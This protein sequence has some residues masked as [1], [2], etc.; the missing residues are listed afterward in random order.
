[1]AD[2]SIA[3]HIGEKSMRTLSCLSTCLCAAQSV[4]IFFSATISYD[5]YVGRRYNSSVLAGGSSSGGPFRSS[6]NYLETLSKIHTHRKKNI[7]LEYDGNSKQKPKHEIMFRRRQ[8]KTQ[9]TKL[10]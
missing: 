4:Q 5:I 3:V 9:D 2:S 10:S 1:M 6:T 8:M 7:R